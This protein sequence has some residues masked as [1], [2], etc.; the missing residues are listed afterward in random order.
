M[1]R[2]V[3]WVLSVQQRRFETFYLDS[4]ACYSRAKR[5]WR[6]FCKNLHWLHEQTTEASSHSH[7]DKTWYPKVKLMTKNKHLMGGNPLV[8]FNFSVNFIFTNFHIFSTILWGYWLHGILNGNTKTDHLP[9]TST[10][11][12]KII[13]NQSWLPT[14]IHLIVCLGAW[15]T[16]CAK[17]T[18]EKLCQIRDQLQYLGIQST[19]TRYF[20]Q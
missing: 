18:I 6:S 15:Y 16:W 10:L 14:L 11:V 9:I 7:L 4:S 5:E 1:F 20:T 12:E 8:S 13:R 3:P 2:W 19:E 17:I